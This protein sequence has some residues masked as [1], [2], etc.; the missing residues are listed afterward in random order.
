MRL[1]RK[2]LTAVDAATTTTPYLAEKITETGQVASV[3]PNALNAQQISFG[4]AHENFEVRNADVVTLAFFS[5][6][7]THDLDFLEARDAIIRIMEDYV[8]VRFVVVGYF[9]IDNDP[10]FAR[11]VIVLRRFPLFPI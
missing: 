3:I 6:T 7:K 2:F 5:G 10:E 11:L 1:Y 4:Q 9:D 8:N